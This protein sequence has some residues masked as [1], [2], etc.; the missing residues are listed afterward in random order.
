M[1]GHNDGGF[2]CRIFFIITEKYL[3]Y[4][5]NKYNYKRFDFFWKLIVKIFSLKS[6]GRLLQVM[7]QNIE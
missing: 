2:F 3:K 6:K 7:R 4:G 5:P 1:K